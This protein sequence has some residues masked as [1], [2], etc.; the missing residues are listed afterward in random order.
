MIMKKTQLKDAL[1]NIKKQLVSW[2]S[3]IV[4]SS[5]AVA[6]YLGLTYS[7]YG[8]SVAGK[9][10]YESTNF[11]DFQVSSNCMLSEDDIESIKN[12]PGIT[13]AEG[14]YRINAKIDA[15][16]NTK[17]I[18]VASV[19][20]RIGLT[21]M[22]SGSLPTKKDECILEQ[23]L[24][25]KLNIA[26]GDNLKLTDA[27]EEDIPE[28]TDSE[29]TVTGT[30]IHAEHA[31]F[32]MD[33]SYCVLVTKDAFDSEKLDH[34][35]SLA[36]I[37]FDHGNYEN[38][39]DDSYFDDASPYKDA[40]EELGKSRAKE[41]YENHISFLK[42]QIEDSKKELS[43]AEGEL[44]L[45]ERMVKSMDSKTGVVMSDLSNM[46]SVVISEEPSEYRTPEE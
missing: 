31:T 39:F 21:I 14:I 26:V 17:D 15:G 43:S 37:T 34:C 24:A 7:A 32:D 46:L 2:L 11:R 28:L 19:P 40:L 3:I 42:D 18:Y 1:R 4:I 13:D 44:K 23:N 27:Y 30:F 36:D 12:I 22:K 20:E 25:E 10:L 29:F 9:N 16:A 45:A 41:R 33:E 38:I 8:L 5:F 35:Y 6:A